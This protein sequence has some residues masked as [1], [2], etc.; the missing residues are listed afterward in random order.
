MRER[1]V[2]RLD[3]RTGETHTVVQHPSTALSFAERIDGLRA[4]ASE[5]VGE[6]ADAAFAALICDAC[7]AR[8]TIDVGDARQPE[9][10]VETRNGDL[11]ADCATR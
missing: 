11:C 5:Q 2:T 3:R 7:H 4:A 10:W 9:G 6:P 8:A 1:V